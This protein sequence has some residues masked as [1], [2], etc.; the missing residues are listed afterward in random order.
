M[1]R[2]E[3]FRRKKREIERVEGEEVGQCFGLVVVDCTPE[4][5]IPPFEHCF[6]DI[7]EYRFLTSYT[8]LNNPQY[9]HDKAEDQ[10]T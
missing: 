6:K 8:L 3:K 4:R 1:K 5:Q 10:Q 2:N 9:Q 7:L